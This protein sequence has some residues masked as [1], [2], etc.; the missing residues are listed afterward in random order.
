M[1]ATQNRLRSRGVLRLEFLWLLAG[2][3]GTVRV[4]LLFPGSNS[5]CGGLSRHLFPD[6][7]FTGVQ[8]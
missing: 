7:T 2:R 5:H 6:C 3:T 8:G 4:A 1:G